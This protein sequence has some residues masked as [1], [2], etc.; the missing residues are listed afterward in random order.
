MPTFQFDAR[1]VS[2]AVAAR[3]GLPG[4]G[5]VSLA[6]ATRR[7]FQLSG[8]KEPVKPEVH[9]VPRDEANPLGVKRQRNLKRAEL[10]MLEIV[11]RLPGKDM[12]RAALKGR[13]D[14]FKE[15]VEIEIAFGIQIVVDADKQLIKQAF[16]EQRRGEAHDPLVLP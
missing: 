14:R 3:S 16:A 5:L 9:H 7:V 1:P 8:R 13:P 2:A 12:R 10:L 15:D 4:L 11:A 6:V